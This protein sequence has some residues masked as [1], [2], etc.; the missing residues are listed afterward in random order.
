MFRPHQGQNENASDTIQPQYHYQDQPQ[1]QISPIMMFVGGG[2]IVLVL[3]ILIATGHIGL[4]FYLLFNLLGGGRGGGGYRGGGF[5]GDG[6]GNDDSNVGFGGG[7]GGGG[8][9]GDF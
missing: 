4:L 9:S 8:A 2:I 1:I 3:G 5:G 6:G 7:S